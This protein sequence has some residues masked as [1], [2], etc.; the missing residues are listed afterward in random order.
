MSVTAYTARIGAALILGKRKNLEFVR[1][2][3]GFALFG[4]VALL[5]LT[6]IVPDIE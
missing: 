2:E 3:S 1:G 4:L 5:F 6:S